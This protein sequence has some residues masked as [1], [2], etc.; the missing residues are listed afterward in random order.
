[1]VVGAGRSKAYR[2]TKKAKNSGKS[3]YSRGQERVKI[4]EG[5]PGSL[6]TQAVL[7][8]YS[9]RTEWL[10]QGISVFAFESD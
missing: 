3:G 9:L 1:M 6:E 4:P 5:R 7:L 10:L 8:C 2:V